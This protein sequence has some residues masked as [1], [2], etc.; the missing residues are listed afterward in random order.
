MT[1]TNRLDII[2]T[3]LLN[4]LNATSAQGMEVAKKELADLNVTSREFLKIANKKEELPADF[5]VDKML[6]IPE[7]NDE[8]W[9]EEQRT[10]REID[11][12]EQFADAAEEED[13]EDDNYCCNCG[14]QLIPYDAYGETHWMCEDCYYGR[15]NE[16]EG[17]T[18]MD[19][20]ESGYFD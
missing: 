6:V 11:D 20:N 15:N 17:E 1:D 16:Y 12:L 13:D 7:E 18:G 10:Q 8:E 19:W 9:E 4:I 3:T 5:D 14:N 2:Q